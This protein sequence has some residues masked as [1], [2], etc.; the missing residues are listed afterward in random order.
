MR[1]YIPSAG[2]L[3]F[4]IGI[5]VY[6]SYR[7][8]SDSVYGLGLGSGMLFS[9]SFLAAIVFG[10]ILPIILTIVLKVDTREYFVPRLI[11]YLSTFAATA[12]IPEFVDVPRGGFVLLTAVSSAV[13]MIY[14]YK[15]CRT[16][17]SEWFVILLST[18]QIYMMIYFLLL[19][20][21]IER[22]L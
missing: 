22:L 20:K 6:S 15:I 17:F 12:V 18:P 8:I 21:D 16:R 2:S 13:T 19:M 7:F 4:P 1:L 3:A 9:L 10:G 11:I 14:F 5:I